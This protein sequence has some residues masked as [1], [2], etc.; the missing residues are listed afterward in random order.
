MNP[1]EFWKSK[2][3]WFN[4]IAFVVVVANAFGFVGFAPDP[5]LS[6]YAGV[7]ITL[8]NLVLRFATSQPVVLKK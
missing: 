7:V 6:E 4:V 1:K 2:T 3:F 8:I 5:Q